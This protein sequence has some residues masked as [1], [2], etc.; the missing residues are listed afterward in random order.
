MIKQIYEIYSPCGGQCVGFITKQEAEEQTIIDVESS[1]Q[2]PFEAVVWLSE[3]E[4]DD[5]KKNR[6]HFF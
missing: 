3:V 5:F 6:Y 2:G 4:W 1:S